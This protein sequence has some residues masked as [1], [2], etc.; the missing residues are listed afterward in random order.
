MHRLYSMTKG[1]RAK[2]ASGRFVRVGGAQMVKISVSET[3]S[4]EV[5]V[6]CVR[7]VLGVLG[8]STI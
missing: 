4:L 1:E 8:I 2:K 6:E 3:I 7:E 5:P